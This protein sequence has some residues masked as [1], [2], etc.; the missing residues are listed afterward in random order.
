MGIEGEAGLSMIHAPARR[1][2]IW[3][4]LV[5]V[6]VVAALILIPFL[7]WEEELT[8]LIR[9]AL[10]VSRGH[11]RLTALIII[12]SLAGDI[13]LP[14]PSSLVSTAAGASLGTI[15]LGMNMACLL[16]Y[17]L[18]RHAGRGAMQ[19]LVG[20]ADVERARQR[21]TGAGAVALVVTRAVPVLAESLVLGAGAVGM[22]LLPFVLLTSAANLV[23]SIAYAALGALVL[24]EDSVL[25]LFSGLAV[26]P[27]SGWLLWLRLKR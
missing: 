12:A 4:W 21:L 25:L 20:E 19:R 17:A 26:I 11:G 18:G 2:R 6:V 16:G 24:S 8:A 23:V 7:L 10:L 22:P 14:V 9:S 27:A 3:R 15:W 5:L 13:L 1:R